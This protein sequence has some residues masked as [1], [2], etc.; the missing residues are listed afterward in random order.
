MSPDLAL[1]YCRMIAQ[2]LEADG[3][4]QA[5][6]LEGTGIDARSGHRLMFDK[7]CKLRRDPKAC[8]FDVLGHAEILSKNES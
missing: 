1:T 3:A 4:D 8:A 5:A 2:T 7:I 6:L